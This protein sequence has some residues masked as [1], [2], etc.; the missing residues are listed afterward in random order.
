[1]LTLLFIFILVGA[2]QISKYFITLYLA[3]KEPL[4]IIPGFLEF[5]YL[6]NKGAAFGILQE[7]RILFIIIT[8]IV[9]GFIVYALTHY[10]RNSSLFYVSLVL[11]LA[12]TLGNFIDRVRLHYV[13]DFI[14]IRI[15]GFNFAIF[16]L[17]DVF[18]VCGTIL[19]MI[20]ILLH[21]GKEKS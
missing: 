4:S 15:F 17:A 18:I 5:Y 13:V 8:I 3:G 16:N 19:L 21:D 11:I 20:Y 10:N 14:K 1:M 12:G 2:D 6:E 9:V 7:K